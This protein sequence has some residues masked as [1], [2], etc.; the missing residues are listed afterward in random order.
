MVS[1]VQNVIFAAIVAPVHAPVRAP[2]VPEEETVAIVAL[3]RNCMKIMG[4]VIVALPECR[5]A[6]LYRG[7][8]MNTGPVS[9]SECFTPSIVWILK[10]LD[11]LL[12]WG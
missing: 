5:A 8:A 7:K 3:N 2:G 10:K 11:S 1:K 4:P 6:I 12:L 9:I